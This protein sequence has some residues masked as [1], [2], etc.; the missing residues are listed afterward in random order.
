M[1]YNAI[2][3]E[4]MVHALSIQHNIPGF[5]LGEHEVDDNI[6][7]RFPGEEAQKFGVLPIHADKGADEITIA[8]LDPENP[9]NRQAQSKKSTGFPT[10]KCWSHRKRCCRNSSSSTT[11]S[12]SSR[13]PRVSPSSCPSS[14][15]AKT[16]VRANALAADGEKAK[17]VLMIS[18]AQ[19]TAMFLRPVFKREGFDLRVASDMDEASQALRDGIFDRIL[20]AP[21]SIDEFNEMREEGLIDPG[22]VEVTPLSSISETLMNTPAPYKQIMRSLM[23][24]LQIIAE[25][26]CARIGWIPPYM[27]I[28]DDVARLARRFHFDRVAVDGLRATTYLL[29]PGQGAEP[30]SR[31]GS[32]RL[33]FIDMEKSARYLADATLPLGHSQSAQALHRTVVA[34]RKVRRLRETANPRLFLVHS[35]WRLHGFATSLSPIFRAD[36]LTPC[37]KSRRGCAR[38][39]RNWRALDVIEAYV[40]VLE[41]EAKS[42]QLRPFNQVFVVGRTSSMST[43]FVSRIKRAGFQTVMIED[44]AEALRLCERQAPAAVLVHRESFP[45][46]MTGAGSAFRQTAVTRLFAFSG[47]TEA[48]TVLDL[49]DAGFDDVFVPPH[50]YDIIAA[51]IT[52]S[53]NGM[54]DQRDSH[55][56]GSFSASFQAFSFIDLIQALGQSLRSV[57]ITVRSG[58]GKTATIFMDKGRLSHAKC[59]KLKGEES[60]LPCH[61]L[62]R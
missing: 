49:L 35:F 9:V 13:T 40:S 2:V 50:D 44:I 24:S 61:Q 48:S 3:E 15:R 30:S 6:V 10:S 23:R 34:Q 31:A 11:N 39:L 37:K 22:G 32:G 1:H 53:L 51:R 20:I 29:M 60:G 28:A 4:Q 59:G 18:M 14:S 41:D 57:K 25:G 27:T 38:W 17:P 12:T 56:K 33:T 21:D 5:H 52:K 58:A 19:G 62:G 7:N 54:P 55:K 46:Q 45:N 47:D 36:R 8:V 42:G 43:E 26:R 16:P